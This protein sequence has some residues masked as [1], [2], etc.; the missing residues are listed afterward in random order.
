MFDRKPDLVVVSVIQEIYDKRNTYCALTSN[1]GD[2][3]EE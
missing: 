2:V 3:K 1:S